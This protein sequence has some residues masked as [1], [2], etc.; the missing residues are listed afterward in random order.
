MEYAKEL[1]YLG[2]LHDQWLV[3][4]RAYKRI[5]WAIL[6][7]AMPQA[8]RKGELTDAQLVLLPHFKSLS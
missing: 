6:I 3:A 5:K 4:H 1:V 8:E 2:E 7:H